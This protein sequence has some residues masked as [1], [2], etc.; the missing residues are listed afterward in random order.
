MDIN[1]L[2]D[3]DARVRC[4]CIYQVITFINFHTHF[5]QDDDEFA[6][7]RKKVREKHKMEALEWLKDRCWRLLMVANKRKLT[8]CERLD[9]YSMED[10][11]KSTVAEFQQAGVNYFKC[12]MANETFC[13]SMPSLMGKESLDDSRV[14]SQMW[15]IKSQSERDLLSSSKVRRRASV[16]DI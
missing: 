5:I 11:I 16:C 6:S 10:E 3:L 15:K 8:P 2:K 14:T 13:V 7:M 12:F 1:N 4:H 9:L